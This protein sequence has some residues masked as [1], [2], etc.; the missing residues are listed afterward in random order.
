[1]V[2]DCLSAKRRVD[3]AK[4][5]SK[6]KE[7]SVREERPPAGELALPVLNKFYFVYYRHFTEITNIFP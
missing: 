3:G 1:M 7:N 4:Q 2:S 6:K 5:A